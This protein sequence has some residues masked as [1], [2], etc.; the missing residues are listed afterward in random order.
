MVCPGLAER[1]YPVPVGYDT[2]GSEVSMRRA[3]T[4]SATIGTSYEVRAVASAG[5]TVE[6]VHDSFATSGGDVWVEDRRTDASI[7]LESPEADAEATV[8]VFAGS[9]DTSIRV[10]ISD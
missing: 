3:L 7:Y 10:T 2:V 9:S 5:T 6:S 8:Y 4:E 1:M